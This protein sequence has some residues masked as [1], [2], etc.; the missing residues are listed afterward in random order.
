MDGPEIPIE[1]L[2]AFEVKKPLGGGSPEP[3][4]PPEEPGDGGDE[5]T[6]QLKEQITQLLGVDEN[7][8]SDEEKA[9]LEKHK[10]FVATQKQDD[11]AEVEARIAE[12]A[13]KGE[14]NLTDEE[15]KF[16]EDNAEAVEAYVSKD[17]SV[18]QLMQAEGFL[19]EGTFDNSMEGLQAYLAKR[20]EVAFEKKLQNYFED[21][22]MLK[23]VKE[24]L[25]KKL[26]IQSLF[27]RQQKPA[28]LANEL[29]KIT[30]EMDDKAKANVTKVY[31]Q[32]IRQAYKSKGVDDVAIE[33]I[34]K[35][36]QD[37]GKMADTAEA[38]KQMLSADF[39]AQIEAYEKEEQA[40]VDAQLE[41][42]QQERNQ[43]IEIVTKN[44]FGGGLKIPT[45]D[46]EGFKNYVG[47]VVKSDG[48]TTM[49]D[50]KYSKLT[51]A[52]KLWLDYIVYKDFKLPNIVTNTSKLLFGKAN[53][54]NSKRTPPGGGSGGSAS[55]SGSIPLL[56]FEGIANSKKLGF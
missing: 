1:K 2:A 43:A 24:H 44:D 47:K 55:R 14:E 35:T 22:P 17:N 4:D 36:A 56:D 31:E 51:L 32:L 9:L 8:R 26:P 10:D 16:L 54:D 5:L 41:A 7:Q 27:M 38:A 40:A 19:E 37:G 53:K 48:V 39:D 12:L 3:P 21:Q 30:D 6:D 11:G 15:K 13:E 18:L 49:S 46:I 23:Q 45:A 20:D 42:L 29:P 34:V 28:I 52:Q 33:A 50:E 25:D